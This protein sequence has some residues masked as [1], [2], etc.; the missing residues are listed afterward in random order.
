MGTEE[1]RARAIAEGLQPV[2]GAA[3]DDDREPVDG[4]GICLSGGGYRAMLFHLGACIRL[5]ELG[6]LAD[7]ARVSSV[8]GGSITAAVVATAW[9][10]LTFAGSVATNFDVEVAEPILAFSDVSIDKRSVLSGILRPGRRISDYVTAAYDKHLYRGATLASFPD[11]D[12]GPRFVLNATNVQTGKLFRMSRPYL[13]DY[14]I[15]MWRQPDLRVAEAVCASSAFPPYLSPHR[16]TPRGQFV[17]TPNAANDAEAFREQVYLSDGGVYD[18]LGLETVWK[19][20]RTVIVSDGGGH[21]GAEEK[22]KSDWAQHGLR[23][24]NIA[25][26][27]VRALRRKQAVASFRAGLRSG[28]YWSV[29]S[30]QSGYQCPDPLSLPASVVAE[31]QR[32]PTRL[33]PVSDSARRALVQWGYVIADTAL[34]RWVVPGAAPPERLPI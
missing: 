23:V 5:N 15:G 31:A 17:A 2:V 6:L 8:S 21:L 11:D 20:Y 19:R 22:P 10:K 33:A 27:Q 32:V 16:I 7:A 18:N 9:S 14:T 13:A 28:T 24:A 34:R 26:G 30:D 12:H 29:H 4:I 1:D 3:G 25:D